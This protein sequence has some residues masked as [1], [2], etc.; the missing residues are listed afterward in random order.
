MFTFDRDFSSYCE[1]AGLV[2]T[3]YAD[4]IF[5]STNEPGKLT[6]AYNKLVLC[7]LNF[8]YADLKINHQKTAF[9]SRKYCRKITGLVIT[10]DRKVSIGRDRKR[11]IKALVPQFS[12]GASDIEKRE[13]LKGMIALCYDADREFYN[14]LVQKYGRRVL[15]GLIG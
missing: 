12:R 11:E 3:R 13:Y 5:V 14:S 9:L 1:Q 15:S 6:E 2:Y 4:D 7:A 10:T 8:P